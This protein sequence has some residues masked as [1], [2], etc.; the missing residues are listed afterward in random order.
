MYWVPTATTVSSDT[1]KSM[2]SEKPPGSLNDPVSSHAAGPESV[3]LGWTDGD[4]LG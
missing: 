4:T 1:A 3:G 2:T